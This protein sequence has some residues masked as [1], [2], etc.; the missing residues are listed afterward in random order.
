MIRRPPRS[1]RTD[2]LFPYTTLFRSRECRTSGSSRGLQHVGDVVEQDRARSEQNLVELAALEVDVGKEF[3]GET[4]PA[5]ELDAVARDL[6]H[7]TRH[8]MLGR[9]R[10][11]QRVRRVVGPAGG[12]F[13]QPPRRA[14]DWKGPP[15]N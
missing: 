13:D 9:Q 5:V 15:L 7:G 3:G 8:M 14:Q 4:D 12:L 11:E 10:I 1:T 6:G 2:T